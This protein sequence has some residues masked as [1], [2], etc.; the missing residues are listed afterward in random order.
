VTGLKGYVKVKGKESNGIHGY[1]QAVPEE[2]Q[3]YLRKVIS[4]EY[5]YPQYPS[6]I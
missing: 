5:K 3:R 6:R 2:V 4:E 1:V